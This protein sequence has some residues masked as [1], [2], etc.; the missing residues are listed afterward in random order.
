MKNTLVKKGMIK[1][2]G[3]VR[4]A[5]SAVGHALLKTKKRKRLEMQIPRLQEEI[6]KLKAQQKNFLKGEKEWHGKGLAASMFADRLGA[7]ALKREAE[8][9]MLKITL[10]RKVKQLIT[11][12]RK[13]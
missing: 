13:K 2:I 6:D 11:L 1:K 12:L 8:Q 7:G 3:R 9:E 5:T 10:E 4:R